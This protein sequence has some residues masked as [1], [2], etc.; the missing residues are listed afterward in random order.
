MH[1]SFGNVTVITLLACI[2]LPGLSAAGP[3]RTLPPNAAIVQ[4]MTNQNPTPPPSDGFLGS[5]Y[6][7][8]NQTGDG[9]EQILPY[10]NP[11]KT[12]LY[13]LLSWQ[14]ETI[15]FAD[16]QA[17]EVNRSTAIFSSDPLTV[18]NAQTQAETPH[19]RPLGEIK[20]GAYKLPIFLYMPNR[21]VDQL[22]W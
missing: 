19:F 12:A 9:Q 10:I 16:I 3:I 5:D 4:R 13:S 17:D 7:L 20:I 2:L 14:P 21:Q 22:S 15:V 8:L 6:G 18:T 11:R 1:R